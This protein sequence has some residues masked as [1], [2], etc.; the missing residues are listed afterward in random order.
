MSCYGFVYIIYNRFRK[1][2]E[3]SKRKMCNLKN[4]VCVYLISFVR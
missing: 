3:F 1:D 4:K 2:V